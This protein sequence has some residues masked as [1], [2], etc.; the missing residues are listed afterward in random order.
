MDSRDDV[1]LYLVCRNSR[2]VQ[3][4]N[5]QQLLA[6]SAAKQYS[7]YTLI[8]IVAEHNDKS[9]YKKKQALEIT[10]WKF[11]LAKL[12]PYPTNCSNIASH[13]PCTMLLFAVEIV[14]RRILGYFML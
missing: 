6:H 5:R 12:H 2:F 3:K 13:P 8:R 14:L 10:F 11:I 4:L 7:V 9:G 1:K